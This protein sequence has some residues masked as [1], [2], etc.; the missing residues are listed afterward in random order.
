MF[1][2]LNIALGLLP[3]VF[4]LGIIPHGTMAHLL[5]EANI[6]QKLQE[7]IIGIFNSLELF[8]RQRNGFEVFSHIF[9]LLLDHVENQL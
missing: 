8:V 2:V 7:V 9:V 4:V 3:D 6:L 1:K 5:C